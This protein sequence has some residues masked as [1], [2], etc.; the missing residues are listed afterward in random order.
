MA[1]SDVCVENRWRSDKII[2][3]FTQKQLFNFK[4]LSDIYY[5]IAVI[6]D[7]LNS[8]TLDGATISNSVKS[9]RNIQKG[10]GMY[11]GG[12]KIEI[13]EFDITGKKPFNVEIYKPEMSDEVNDS[14]VDDDKYHVFELKSAFGTGLSSGQYVDRIKETLNETD[15]YEKKIKDGISSLQK[16]LKEMTEK[17]DEAAKNAKKDNKEYGHTEYNMDTADGFREYL[18]GKMTEKELIEFL[19]E[20]KNMTKYP[21]QYYEIQKQYVLIYRN[22]LN[23]ITTKLIA[24]SELKIK[25]AVEMFCEILA[26]A[27]PMKARDE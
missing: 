2:D 15:R 20:D 12:V 9:M 6:I 26:S 10:S 13:S 16:K 22:I 17:L 14:S 21:K 3:I 8:N 27:K 5:K 24:V 23:E 19:K 11:P 4:N 18:D 7:S 25:K 1:G